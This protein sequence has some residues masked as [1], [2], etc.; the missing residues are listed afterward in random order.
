M[1]R[2]APA[3]SRRLLAEGAHVVLIGRATIYAPRGRLQFSADEA[4]PVGRGALLEALSRL[5]E[6]LVG[7]GLFAPERKRPLPPDPRVIGVITSGN[8]AA[9]HDIVTVAFRRAKVRLLFAR[10]AVQ[11]AGAAA[12]M[13]RAIEL[14]ERVPEV[15]V[16]IL[17]RG[18]GSADDLAAFNDEALV[19]KVAAARV[20]IVSAVGHEIDVSLTDL[21]ADARAATPSQAAEMLVPDAAARSASLEHLSVRMRRAI[22]QRLRDDEVALS[23][24]TARLGTPTRLYERWQQQI[25]DDLG[26]IQFHMEQLLAERQREIGLLSRRLAARHP[27]AV[28]EGARAMLAPLSVSLGAAM[29]RGVAAQRR[30][31]EADVGRLHALSPLAVL[32]RGYAIALDGEGRLIHDARGVA[33]GDA[34]AVRVAR[35]RIEAKVTR[36][37]EDGS[38]SGEG[39]GSRDEGG[40]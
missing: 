20:P 23:R 24:L 8:G 27:R 34:I 31:F 25:D 29:R 2:T 7:E 6:K 26:R 18:G 37:L 11:G 12:Q 40:R 15:S 9:I 19:R 13:I 17:G 3:R 14:L 33:P 1:Y 22:E 30:R 39:A 21:A 16:I 28:L 38:L 10:A 5:K 35:G 32:S 36:A 4:R